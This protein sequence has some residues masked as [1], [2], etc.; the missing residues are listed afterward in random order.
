VESLVK[1]RA[2]KKKI[3][4]NQ[5]NGRRKVL[6]KNVIERPNLRYAN[7]YNTVGDT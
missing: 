3:L 1:K 5:L 4:K 6:A 2:L 7:E